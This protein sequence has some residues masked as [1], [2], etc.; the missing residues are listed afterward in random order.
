[1]PLSNMAAFFYTLIMGLKV[2]TEGMSIFHLNRKDLR[3]FGC[4][5]LPEKPSFWIKIPLQG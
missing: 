2:Y 5:L 3:G 1:M 4:D